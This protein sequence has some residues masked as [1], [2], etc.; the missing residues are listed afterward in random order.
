MAN[1]LEGISAAE[2]RRIQSKANR[3]ISDLT[4]REYGIHKIMEDNKI[5]GIP[6]YGKAVTKN[7]GGTFKG[8]F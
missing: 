1:G 6:N 5:A 8:T 2:L 4:N 3:N 7:R